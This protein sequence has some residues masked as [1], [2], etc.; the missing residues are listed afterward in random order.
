MLSAAPR[1]TAALRAGEAVVL[2]LPSPLPYGVFGTSPA[3]VNRAKG[4][5]ENQPAGIVVADFGDFAPYL[6]VTAD[7]VTMIEW[8][9]VTAQLN[10][11]APLTGAAPSWLVQDQALTGGAVGMM[12]SWLP[13]LRDV[14]A[15]FGHL[16]VSSAN[17]T[18]QAVAVTAGEAD[19]SFGGR[20][21]VVDGDAD[22]DAGRPHGSATIVRVSARG[23]L[24][25]TRRGIN[26]E[27]FDGDNDAYLAALRRQYE[28]AAEGQSRSDA[29]RAA[30]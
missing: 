27:S 21:L 8:L 14:L 6:A 28:E 29:G 5:P 18:K 4:R 20:L 26:N 13:G 1:V 12:G 30:W 23:Q 10:V 7:T 15:A 9:C 16:F 11:F 22:R 17:K 3:V 25:V 2:P 24:T 19:E